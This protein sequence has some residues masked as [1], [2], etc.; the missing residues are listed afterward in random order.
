MTDRLRL[1]LGLSLVGL[2]V[3]AG[4]GCEKPRVYGEWV[5]TGHVVDADTGSPIG[6]AKVYV[7]SYLAVPGWEGK[8]HLQC[9]SDEN[10][11]FVVWYGSGGLRL[12]EVEKDGYLSAAQSL[13]GSGEL[14]FPLEKAV[15]SSPNGPAT[16]PPRK[17][18][19]MPCR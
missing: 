16:P 3:M 10:G 11:E 13:E 12:F 6:G 2:F 14:Y 18:P 8:R 1:L 5:V 9:S 7:T 17:S 19:G 15:P 4:V